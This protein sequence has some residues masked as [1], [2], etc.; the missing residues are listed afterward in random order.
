[1]SVELILIKILVLIPTS[2]IQ[3]LP[4]SVWSPNSLLPNFL[5]LFINEEPQNLLILRYL[6]QTKNK[7]ISVLLLSNFT[8]NLQT[9]LNFSW[10][11]YEF[12]VIRR[13]KNKEGRKERRKE[14]RKEGITIT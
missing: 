13:K 9:Q 11:E 5:V 8:P 12:T 14:G 7:L 4:L 10:T 3:H 1:M 6:H 2:F